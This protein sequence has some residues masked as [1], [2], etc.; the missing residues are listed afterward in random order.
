LDEVVLRTLEKE[1]EQRYQHASDLKT[2]VDDI[3]QAGS[4]RAPAADDALLA[5]A[6]ISRSA[7][8]GAAWAPWSLALIPLVLVTYFVS[9]QASPASGASSAAVRADGPN[10][11][12]IAAG[13]VC[14]LLSLTAPFGTTILGLVAISQI[15]RSRGKLYG[16]ALAVADALL[17]PLLLLDALIVTL[18]AAVVMTILFALYPDGPKGKGALSLPELLTLITALPLAAWADFLI[19]RAVW[20]SLTGYMPQQAP[21]IRRSSQQAVPVQ[22]H[23]PPPGM[24]PQLLLIGA[25]I[26]FSLLVVAAGAV[27]AALAF[28][29]AAPGGNEFWG[30]MGGAFGCMVGGLGSLAGCWNTY[31][32]LA[33]GAN[34]MYASHWTWLDQGVAAYTTAG[35]LTLGAA[36]SLSA[37]RVTMQAL[38]TIGGMMIFQGGLFLI[39]RAVLRRSAQL[40][41]SSPLP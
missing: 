13:V 12:L 18:V 9:A 26:F 21:I 5:G 31:R 19:V 29:L 23:V 39:I 36:F 38:L 25:M 10:Y 4:R 1:P 33:G 7:V 24:G 27:L 14:G 37:S 32:Q 30:W 41:E 6:R 22:S 34:I 17:F 20:R 16:L 11:V 15:R 40:G 28:V 35:A 8:V 2:A 3:A